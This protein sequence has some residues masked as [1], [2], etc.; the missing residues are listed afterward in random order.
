MRRL[1]LLVVLVI[2]GFVYCEDALYTNKY[3]SIDY[4]EILQ[5]ERL[6]KN[7]YNCLM[8]K[9]PCTADGKDLKSK[10]FC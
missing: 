4:R 5:S 3:D 9:G 2:L 1:E 10:I 7:Y 6:L 8:D